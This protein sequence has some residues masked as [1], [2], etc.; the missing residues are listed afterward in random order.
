MRIL[1]GF[2]V[3]VL[4][5]MIWILFSWLGA[6]WWIS[7]YGLFSDQE[8]DIFMAPLWITIPMM[9][10]VFGIIGGPLYYWIVEPIWNQLKDEP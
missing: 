9:I 10:G 3:G 8:Y 5:L 7:E 6:W 1:R 2:C 4:C